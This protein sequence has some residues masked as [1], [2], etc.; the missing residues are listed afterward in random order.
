MMCC[1]LNYLLRCPNKIL[2]L[3]I[4]VFI[5]LLPG[6]CLAQDKNDIKEIFNI[7]IREELVLVENGIEFYFNKINVDDS[8][9][10]WSGLEFVWLSVPRSLVSLNIVNIQREG[11]NKHLF[12]NVS[13]SKTIASI[14]GGFYKPETSYISEG[15]LV[16]DGRVINDQFIAYGHRLS[17]G[18]ILYQAGNT[19]DIFP[20]EFRKF[21]VS[22][23]PKFAIQ[24]MPIVVYNEQNDISNDDG[25]KASRVGIGI[26]KSD[27]V[28]FAGAFNTNSQQV[29]SL[30]EFGELLSYTEL[31][32]GPGARV[33][34]GLDGG[35]SA[36][37]YVPSIHRHF[38]DFGQSQLGLANII[39]IVS[40]K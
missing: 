1:K 27:K 14:T 19:I 9:S 39:S 34:I 2:M 16:I 32:G 12:K 5:Y 25:E 28:I 24:S 11:N 10:R 31:E 21:V 13:D 22:K 35:P 7:G 17:K 6:I 26:S 30:F 33:F 36:H 37:L 15:Y 4:L 29:I 38:N 23:N 8:S 40:K 3:F 18:G 20:Y